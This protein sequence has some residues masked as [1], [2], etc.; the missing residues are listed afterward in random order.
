MSAAAPEQDKIVPIRE[1]VLLPQQTSSLV[2]ETLKELLAQAERGEIAAFAYVKVDPAA[3][4]YTDWSTHGVREHG[5]AMVGGVAR[6]LYRL[7][8]AQD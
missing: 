7:N 8:K 4:I 5:F 1:T 2:I 3:N 6:L